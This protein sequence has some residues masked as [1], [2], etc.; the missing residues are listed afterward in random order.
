MVKFTSFKKKKKK[1]KVYNTIFVDSFKNDSGSKAG[2]DKCAMPQETSADN[3][4]DALVSEKIFTINSDGCYVSKVM[5]I[6]SVFQMTMTYHLQ[7]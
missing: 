7:S 4:P 1:N 6:M 5:K 2:L 3:F